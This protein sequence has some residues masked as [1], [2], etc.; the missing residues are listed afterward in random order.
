MLL[1]KKSQAQCETVANTLDFQHNKRVI[2]LRRHVLMG[3]ECFCFDS[4]T[5]SY[6]LSAGR[7][8]K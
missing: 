1:K 6:L 8:N 3:E 5:Y 2:Q 7:G 4:N